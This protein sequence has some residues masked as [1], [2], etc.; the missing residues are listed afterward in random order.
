VANKLFKAI[1]WAFNLFFNE[2]ILELISFKEAFKS[3]LSILA[4]I[5]PFFTLSPIFFIY[6]IFPVNLEVIRTFV[7]LLT[8]A[9]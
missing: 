2:L 9:R 5:S 1:I 6:N 4:T 8:C 3:V 7:E